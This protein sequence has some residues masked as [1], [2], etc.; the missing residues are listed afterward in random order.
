M[1]A[2]RSPVRVA[3][4]VLS[5]LRKGAHDLYGSPTSRSTADAPWPLVAYP[6]SWPSSNVSRLFIRRRSVLSA[7]LFLHR[8]LLLP[9]SVLSRPYV[10]RHMC[11]RHDMMSGSF[12]LDD[13]KHTTARASP[14]LSIPLD[15]WFSCV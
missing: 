5:S 1:V 4:S 15:L 8:L 11:R 9:L 7:Q 10:A 14:P 3:T 12:L 6:S 13:D 2:K